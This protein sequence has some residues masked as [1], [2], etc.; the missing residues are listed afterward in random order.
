MHVHAQGRTV[1]QSVRHSLC[2]P[3]LPLALP[4]P[5]PFPLHMKFRDSSTIDLISLPTDFVSLPVLKSNNNNKLGNQRRA[6]HPHNITLPVQ[7]VG[8]GRVR[9]SVPGSSL[10]L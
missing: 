6:H 3:I 9:L 8:L 10:L 1:S 5:R 7:L 2:S 4:G